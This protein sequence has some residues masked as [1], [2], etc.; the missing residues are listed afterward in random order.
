[1]QKI[2][3]IQICLCLLFIAIFNGIILIPFAETNTPNGYKYVVIVNK[4]NH[5]MGQEERVK[6][7]IKSLFL[8]KRSAWPN[9]LLA[10]SFARKNDSDIHKAFVN[11]ILEMTEGQLS[12]YWSS[13]KSKT[14]TKRPREVSSKMVMKLVSKYEGALGYIS[15]AEAQLNKDVISILLEF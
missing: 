7:M 6:S 12:A 14:G 8:K 2:K 11:H 15:N 13:V 9:D 1:M 3:L 4:A 5:Y 10:K